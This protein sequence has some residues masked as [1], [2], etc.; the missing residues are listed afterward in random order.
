MPSWKWCTNSANNV[1]GSIWV[2]WNPG[3][4][5]FNTV[6]N[7]AQHI[8]GQVEMQ[9]SKIKFQFTAVYGLHSIT[10]RIPLWTTIKQ[11]NTHINE[12]WLIMGD[13]NSILTVEDR[14]IGSQVRR[15]ETRD[16]QECINDCNLTKLVTVGRKFTWTNGHVFSR[17]DRALV[18]VEWVL[19]MPIVQVLV[20]DPLFSHHSPLSIIVEEHRDAKKRPF[21]IFNYLAQHPEFKNKINASWQIKGRGMQ[22]VWQNLM[23]VRRELKQLNQREYMGVSEKVHKLRVELMDMQSQMRIIPIPQCMIDEEKEL[24]TQLNKW[25]RIEEAIYKQ[26][27]RVQWLK[28][29]DSNT[30]Y[31][32]ASMKNRKSQNQITML[33]KEDGTIIRDP[34][35]I[36][37]E[38]VRFYQNLL[39]QATPLMLAT[40]PAVVRDGH[41]LSRAQQ[42]ELIQPFTK[43]DV[44][45]A[46]KS[47]EDNKAPGG[48]GFN[49][50]FFKQTW[51][52]IGEEVT[53]DVLQF[54]STNQMYAPINRTSVTL[55]PKVQ[56]PSSIKE[57][58]PISCCTTM[59]KIIFKMLTHRLQGVMDFLVDP[60]QATFVPGRM[61][62]DNVILSHELIKGYGRKGIS[63]RCMFKIDMQKAYDSLEWHF[64]EEVLVDMQLPERFITWIMKCVRTVSY[65]IMINGCP[66]VPFQAR[67]GVRQGDPLSPYLFVLAMDYLTRL[68]RSLRNKNAFK[69]HPRCQKQQIIQLSF[70]DNLLLFSRGDRPSTTLLFECFQQFSKTSG[71]IANQ[72]KSCVYFG[73]VPEPIQQQILQHTGFTKGALPFK[74]LGVPLSSKK[75]S[76][77]QCQTLI[78][79]MVGRI[80][81]WTVKFLSYAGRLQLVQSVLTSIQAFWSQ[82]FL[83]PKKLLQTIETLCKRFLWKGDAQSQWRSQ[84]FQ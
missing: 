11:L 68:L 83:I 70:A 74:Y 44:L 54:F 49:S 5:N 71:L 79:K 65:S 29:G 82:I 7:S 17:I 13:F 52:I 67:R 37:R 36:T 66:S 27:S 9:G 21:K 46:L 63:P 19:H 69:F 25:S 14:P 1:R 76:I 80:N 16:F 61:L 81:T 55:I 15:S 78:D 72:S 23:K 39:G 3:V 26:K 75:L 58:R 40:Q 24:R 64:L 51:P 2:V 22:G 59:Y 34:E 47:I 32:Y 43:D 38:A 35:E 77:S 18:N 6:E 33:T 50:Y 45:M 53:T 73:G 12:P 28:L 62:T 42:L 60:S 56:H 84:D 20:M 31:F 41:V 57:Y 10:A 8:H 4:I 30:S 48:D